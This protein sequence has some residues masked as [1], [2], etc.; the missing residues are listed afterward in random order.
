MRR[1]FIGG[2]TLDPNILA[3]CWDQ[4]LELQQW[5]LENWPNNLRELNEFLPRLFERNPHMENLGPEELRQFSDLRIPWIFEALRRKWGEPAEGVTC[6]SHKDQV[7][8]VMDAWHHDLVGALYWAEKLGFLDRLGVQAF[9]LV[10][11]DK[12]R[13][14]PE[15]MPKTSLRR[16]LED[17]RKKL[18]EEGREV[19]LDAEAPKV[20][21]CEEQK[22]AEYD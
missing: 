6:F 13:S 22:G 7:V 18:N 16:E 4:A 2:K 19:N 17:M 3:H 10:E 12:K 21:H 15:P 9:K 5:V 20:I 8:V 14:G 1:M 11:A